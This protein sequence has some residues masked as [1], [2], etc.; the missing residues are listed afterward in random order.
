MCYAG[1]RREH[2]YAS[3]KWFYNISDLKVVY[4]EEG[5]YVH[6]V[7]HSSFHIKTRMLEVLIVVIL[8]RKRM[9]IWQSSSPLCITMADMQY[10]LIADCDLKLSEFISSY[11]S[12]FQVK[13]KE[14]WILWLMWHAK[15]T[16]FLIC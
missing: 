4:E 16:A 6:P 2:I 12:V 13:L 14:C 9:H 15:L 3:K 11:H 7:A 1:H 10:S 8:C 5:D